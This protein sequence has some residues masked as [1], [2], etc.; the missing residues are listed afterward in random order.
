MKKKK[1]EG[2]RVIPFPHVF[3]L[4][5]DSHREDIHNMFTHIA[6]NTANYIT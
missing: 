2:I 5:E 6:S 4:R 3:D 1:V